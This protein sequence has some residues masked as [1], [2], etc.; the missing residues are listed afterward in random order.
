MLYP[1]SYAAMKL[2]RIV[3]RLC[4]GVKALKA[5]FPRRAQVRGAAK[6]L[7][8]SARLAASLGKDVGNFWLD[9]LAPGYCRECDKLLESGALSFCTDCLAAVEW[10]GSACPRCALPLAHPPPV[11]A[12]GAPAGAGKPVGC[13]AGC[14]ECRPFH[15][16][17]DLAAAGGLYKGPL[18]TAVLRYKFHGDRGVVPLLEE[19][20][21]RAA[22]SQVL[23]ARLP[24]A[25]AIVPVPSHPLKKWWRGRDPVADLARELAPG[26]GGLPVRPLLRKAKWT[27]AQVALSGAKRRRNLKGAFSVRPGAAVPRAVILLDDVLTTGTT[28]SQCALALK[29]GGAEDVTVLAIARS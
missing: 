6:H 1:L 17:F 23:A 22:G 26:L 2:Q 13:V 19:A 4:H 29:K 15:L 16:H 20:L 24:R 5:F 10:I 18:R 9:L 14:W 7:C 27:R 28:A 8:F 21:R 12:A 3:S 11:P 25:Q